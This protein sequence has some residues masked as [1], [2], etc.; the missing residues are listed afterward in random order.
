MLKNKFDVVKE[1]NRFKFVIPQKS[2]PPSSKP[3]LTTCNLNV[4][5]PPLFFE[6]VT[7]KQID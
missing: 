4:T 1:I 7:N 6:S 2:A 3:E 5:P